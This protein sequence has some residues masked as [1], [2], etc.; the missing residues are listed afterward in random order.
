MYFNFAWRRGGKK[1]LRNTFKDTW[2]RFGKGKKV[3]RELLTQK[4]GLE[5]RQKIKRIK[6]QKEV[7]NHHTDKV[8]YRTKHQ[9][10]QNFYT[11]L[12]YGYYC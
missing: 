1:S 8:Q 3:G 11:D 12:V 9:I 7:T 2:N 4:I 10:H 5:R 6:K